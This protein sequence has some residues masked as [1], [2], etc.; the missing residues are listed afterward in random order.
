MPDSR[1]TDLTALAGTAIAVGD[2]IEI[3]DVSNTTDNAAGSSR[4]TTLGDIATALSAGIGLPRVKRLNTDHSLASTTGTEVTDL[5]M[6]LEPG[7]YVVDYYLIV[8]S[9]ATATS[10]L[11]GL[12]FTGTAAVRSF[13]FMF[14]DAT[15]AITAEL[16]TMDDEGVN[17]FGYISGRA[18]RTFTTTAPNLGST[19]TLAVAT[20]N[21]DTPVRITGLL[22]VTASGDLE[23]WHSS[24][25]AASTVVETGSSLVV[26]RTA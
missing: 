11:L 19:A 8:Q 10:P 24:E 1:I 23:L 14:A 7:T 4:K 18:T 17:T 13:I 15:S 16:H 26:V 6:T 3:V 25:T 12:N 9:S 5:S 21:T 2:T 20:A 22:I